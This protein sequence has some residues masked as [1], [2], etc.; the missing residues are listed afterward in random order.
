MKRNRFLIVLLVIAAMIGL[1]SCG[2]DTFTVTFDTNDGSNI[3]AITVLEDGTITVP[4][5]PT[6]EGYTFAGW[7][8]T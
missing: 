6:K 5:A 4:E 3:E 7:Y 2:K 8:L 1:A